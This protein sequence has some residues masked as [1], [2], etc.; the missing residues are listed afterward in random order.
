[1]ATISIRTWNGSA[2]GS[3]TVLTG[4]S[5][6]ARGTVNATQIT[7]ANSLASLNPPLDPRTFGEASISFG[8]LFGTNTCGSFG[9]AYLKSRSSDSFTAAL[10]DFVPP[11]A[12]SI[13]NCAALTTNATQS[14]T[15]GSPISDTATLSGVAPGAGGT[16]TFKAF[17][18]NDANCSGTAAFT[19][20]PI[21]VNGPGNY[22]S[23]NFTPT[24]VGTYRWTASYT[25]DANNQAASSPCNAA[26][27]SSTVNPASPSITT[28]LSDEEIAVGESIHDSATLTGATADAGGTVTYTAYTNDTCTAGARDAGTKTVTNGSVPDSNT[29]TFDTPGD[30]YW[31][32]VYSGDANNQGATSVCTSEHLVVGKAP[33]NIS[34]AQ[35]LF[36][37]DSATVS[38]NAG[39]QPTG[40]VTFKL[41]STADC[42]GTP[43]YEESVTLDN[44]TANTDN[45]SFSVDADNDGAYKW[46]V[47]YSGDATH[48]GVTSACGKEAFT[49]T[50]DDDT[51]T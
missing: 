50:V 8:A 19:S 24:A 44:G 17:G 1:V 29:L 16:I 34:S 40:T 41:Y 26:N 21:T 27:E 2:W 42:S 13:S 35:E 48:E 11:E 43:A 32:A 15:V 36:P 5:A 14:A 20:Q 39:G 37:Q 49:A 33:S 45:T 3:P 47:E 51:T 28:T 38:A 10:K 6:Q 23:G 4:T 46:V 31:Q 22:G 30:F 7:A 12:V 25:G 18:P 9:S